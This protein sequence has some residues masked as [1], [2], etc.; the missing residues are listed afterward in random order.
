MNTLIPMIT[1]IPNRRLIWFCVCR[2]EKLLVEAELV[3]PEELKTGK[4]AGPADESIRQRVLEAED[5]AETIA[6]GSPVAMAVSTPPRFNSGA[7]V[8]AVNRHPMGHTREP[9][10]VRGRVGVIHEYRVH[11]SSRT[12]APRD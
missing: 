2:L 5:V 6:K 4:A 11:M 10:Y 8:R 3:D 1:I 9:R 12:E 7:S